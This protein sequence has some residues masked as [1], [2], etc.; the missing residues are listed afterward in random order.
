MELYNY[1]TGDI[2]FKSYLIW[3]GGEIYNITHTERPKFHIFFPQSK[4]LGILTFGDFDGTTLLKR[5]LFL[6]HWI[7]Y[8]K[9]MHQLV[10]QRVCKVFI[11]IRH[12]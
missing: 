1:H 5:V 9:E 8:Q 7:F 11:L 3:L 6:Q 12:H 4:I 10:R 2:F